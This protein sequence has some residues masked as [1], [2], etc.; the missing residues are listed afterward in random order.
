MANE[1][2]KWN[3]KIQERLTAIRAAKENDTAREAELVRKRKELEGRLRELGALSTSGMKKK[4]IDAGIPEKK[5]DILLTRNELVVTYFGLKFVRD[6][7]KMLCDKMDATIDD[8]NQGK[9]AFA[10]DD[11]DNE[12]LHADEPTE[13]ELFSEPPRNRKDDDDDDDPDQQT[14]PVG[15][16]KGREPNS[17]ARARADGYVGDGAEPATIKSDIQELELPD[18]ITRHLYKAGLD[19]IGKLIEF[20]EEHGNQYTDVEGVGQSSSDEIHATLRKFRRKQ[21][22]AD[23]EKTLAGSP[24]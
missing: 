18:R 19:T 13:A 6:H 12:D 4:M 9:L 2:V 22:A 15:E 20:G 21:R 7:Y 5:V 1:K 17:E 8:A 16:A 11:L 14:L 23:T 24:G 10:E 3:E